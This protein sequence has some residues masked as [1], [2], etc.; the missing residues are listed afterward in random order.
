MSKKINAYQKVSKEQQLA[1]A[2]P[3]TIIVTL[4]DGLLENLAISKGA[5]TRNDLEKK[6]FHLTKAINILR[7]FQDSLD[8][9]SEPQISKNFDELYAYCIEKLIQASLEIKEGPINEVVEL[10]K[11]IRDAWKEMPTTEKDKGLQLLTEK[12]G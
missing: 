12:A 2:D 6:S 11:P 7:S 5:I 3:H 9:K 1:A 10:L 8:E 4:F